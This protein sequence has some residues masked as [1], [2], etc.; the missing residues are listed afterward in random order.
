[1]DCENTSSSLLEPSELLEELLLQFDPKTTN[2]LEMETL[3]LEYGSYSGII[4]LYVRLKQDFL[5]PIFRLTT[6]LQSPSTS[7]AP[8]QASVDTVKLCLTLLA[9]IKDCLMG[10]NSITGT[11]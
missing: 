10:V 7:V 3:A 11:C 8:P 4:S 2:L 1:M 6:L 5:T 9:Y